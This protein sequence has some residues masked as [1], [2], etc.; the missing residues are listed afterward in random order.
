MRTS[1]AVPTS[2]CHVTDRQLHSVAVTLSRGAAARIALLLLVTTYACVPL[3]AA[4][5]TTDKP[6]YSPGESITFTGTGWQPGE[7]VNI[8]IYETSVDPFFDEGGVTAVADADGTISNSDFQCQQSFLGQGFLAHATGASSGVTAEATFTDNINADFRQA[9]NNDAG[10]GLG[11]THW[12]N[13]IVQASNSR[14]YEGM[15]VFQRFIVDGLPATTGNHHSLLFSHEFTKGGVHA[16]DF[17]T[18]WA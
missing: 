9:A 14:Y 16:Y 2:I 5:L 17:L 1:T 3:L 15:S 12:I 10:Y 4:T 18:S 7:T 8:E 6:D 11:N 13:S